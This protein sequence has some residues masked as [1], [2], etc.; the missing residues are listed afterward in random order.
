MRNYPFQN[1]RNCPPHKALS[2]K[3]PVSTVPTVARR[4]SL[5][6]RAG[7]QGELEEFFQ[8][9]LAGHLQLD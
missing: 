9:S 5:E 3:M 6:S 4:E 1:L 8:F 2:S 7:R